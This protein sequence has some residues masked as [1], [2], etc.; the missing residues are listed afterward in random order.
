MKYSCGLVVVM[1]LLMGLNGVAQP[2]SQAVD[3]IATLVRTYYNARQ[4][5]SI[6][7]LTDASFKKAVTGAQFNQFITSSFSELGSW[8]ST[9][10]PRIAADGYHY[11]VHFANGTLEFL[12]TLNNQRQIAALAL[13]P[14]QTP[15]PTRARQN[16]LTN[17]PLQSPLDRQV[18][19][20]VSVYMSK[21]EAVGLSVGILRKDSLFTY[22][23]GET[24]LGS[25][26]TPT[27]NT[28]FEIGSVSKTFTAVLLADAVRQGQVKLDDRAS[29]YLPDS[30]PPLRYDGVDV[31]LRMLANHTSGLPRLPVNLN[32][33]RLYDPQNPYAHYDEQ[34]LFTYL[35]T[36]AFVHKPGTTYDYS[37]LGMGL[38]GTIL[39][40]RT[41]KLYEQLL[42][43]VI[44]KPLGLSN[45]L[46]T[47]PVSKHLAQGYD[48]SGK[49]VHSWEFKALT[50]AGGIR[51]TTD[52]L[53][54]YLQANLGKAPGR[55]RSA[56]QLTQQPTYTD[57]QSQPTVGLGWHIN[58]KTG[59]RWHNGG[60]GGF[61]SFVGFDPKK[62]TGIVVLTNAQIDSPDEV[63]RQLIKAVGL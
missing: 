60:T 31:T 14:V 41:G 7:A 62:K 25:R 15:K 38:L 30:L 39:S 33:S 28:L 6:Y 45:T 22:G 44:A 51:S 32:S 43:E 63:A 55:L 5:D 53:L 29:Q 16:I 19:S 48:Q 8:M 56:L 1:L 17:N 57:T 18:D 59:W 49:A 9:G 20:V 61:R 35:K 10:E 37:N 2:A 46:I 42:T 27:G 24:R 11:P 34:E 36:V 4:A 26:D 13:Q 21:P 52:D 47:L 23:Y 54:L 50:G 40:R 58:P 3:S 12:L